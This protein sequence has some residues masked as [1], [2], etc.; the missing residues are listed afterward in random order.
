M[1]LNE[2]E[3]MPDS[4]IAE[5]LADIRGRIAAA[6]DG[7]GREP[8]EINLVA[9]SKKQPPEVV[10][11]AA[12]CGVSIFGE[13][14]VREMGQK[15]GLC[16]EGLT[17]HFVGHLQGN[18]ARRAVELFHAIHSIDS[19]G[20]LERVNAVAVEAGRTIPVFLQVSVSG[21]ASKFGLAPDAVSPVLEAA[22]NLMNVDVV[23]LMTMPPHTPEPGGAA[24][25]FEAL[26]NLRD[27]LR[28]ATGFPLDGLSMGMSHDFEV[29][30]AEGADW[31]RIGTALLGERSS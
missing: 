7:A 19:L 22:V 20:L 12:E 28:V 9:V 13:N 24:P 31:I 30:I 17:W 27:D 2:R 8:E 14:R 4:T 6:C 10:I 5:R 21:E 11:E 15:V 25:Y 23:G 18:K 1:S 3:D 26:R 16:P 29:A